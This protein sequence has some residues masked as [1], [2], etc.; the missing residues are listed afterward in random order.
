MTVLIGPT[1]TDVVI[2]SDAWDVSFPPTVKGSIKPGTL[3]GLTNLSYID[4][5]VNMTGLIEPGVIPDRYITLLL[6]KTYKHPLALSQFSKR[7]EVRL[8]I[9]NI[10][11][12]PIGKKFV[13]WSETKS[14]VEGK[15]PDRVFNPG[16]VLYT[17]ATNMMGINCYGNHVT[18]CEPKP[19]GPSSLDASTF[20]LWLTE[21]EQA[22]PNTIEA[23]AVADQVA[24]KLYVD[25]TAA[26]KTCKLHNRFSMMYDIGRFG[27]RD[28]YRKIIIDS[29]TTAFPS[30]T[31]APV[32]G[33]NDQIS[34]SY[35]C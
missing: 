7:V 1:Y 18:R 2:P 25:V 5:G 14:D 23:Q 30:L 9:D 19:E 6:P 17:R 20:E 29:L 12:M 24:Q 34:V 3:D 4:W 35:G 32:E 13:V 16:A 31:I 28:T 8:H 27:G 10:E 26:T 15:R 21:S 33:I 11:Q 22:D